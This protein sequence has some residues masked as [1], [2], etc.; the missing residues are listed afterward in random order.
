MKFNQVACVVFV[1]IALVAVSG[2]G[3]TAQDLYDEAA[4]Q[5]KLQQERL[6]NLRPAYDAARQ[7]ALLAVTK[8]FAGATS[9]ENAQNA[10]KQ[11]EGL[12][13]QA[14][15]TDLLAGTHQD[16]IDAAIGHLTTMQAAIEAQQN[17][18]LGGAAKISAA[19]KNIETLGTPENKRFE[20]ILGAMPEVQAF[21]RQEK[22][23]EDATK[24]VLEA[25]S[26][27]AKSEK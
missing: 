4:R 9:D 24:I 11:L 16:Q 10:L 20:E 22:R 2:C 19:T 13:A 23:L 18:L 8:E 21:R 25:E 17:G 5:V 26:K 14:G 12:S 7:K 15:A 3:P 1:A 6:D 27:L